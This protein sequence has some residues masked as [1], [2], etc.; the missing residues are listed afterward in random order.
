[1]AA[2]EGKVAWVTGAGSGIGQ[3]AAIA[4]A[5]EG[6]TVVLTGRRKEALQETAKQVA[7]AG[8]KA[9]VKQGDMM[10]ARAVQSIASFIEQKFG[11]LDILVN[12]A[13]LNIRERSWRQLKPE[14]VD[15]VIGGNLSSAFYC[16]TAALPMMRK[17]KDGV[18]ILSE[19]TGAREQ[20]QSG[21]VVI[22]PC[23]VYATAQAIHQ[24]LV[25]D[26]DQR[27]EQAA[28]LRWLI[29]REDIR[30]WFSKQLEAVDSLN[31]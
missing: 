1:M 7:A 3:A 13:G 29:E 11:R 5:R 17:Q 8:G 20:L 21:A 19:R 31:L 26:P 25:M 28:R 23:D 22:S 2:L 9:A 27:H 30:D 16:V 6:A 18:L 14:G 15:E 24:A 10:K 12:N 4:L